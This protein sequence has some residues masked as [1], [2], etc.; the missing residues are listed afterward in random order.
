MQVIEAQVVD[1]THLELTRPIQ[2]PCG[3]RVLVSIATANTDK[4]HAEWVKMSLQQLQSAYGSEEPEYS[5]ARIRTPNPEF[6]P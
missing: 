6:E 5:V 4:E 3:A 2:A 1:A